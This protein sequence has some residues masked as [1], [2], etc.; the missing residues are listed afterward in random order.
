MQISSLAAWL[1]IYVFLVKYME[2]TKLK[3]SVRACFI[4]GCAELW[5]Y[6]TKLETDIEFPSNLMIKGFVFSVQL[7]QGSEN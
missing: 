4:S 3:I 6:M 7:C 5:Q 2:C 1:W